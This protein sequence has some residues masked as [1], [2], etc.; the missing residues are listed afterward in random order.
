MTSSILALVAA[1]VGACLGSHA[2]TAALRSARGE[3][4][5][6]G[7]SRCDACGVTLNY[8]Q[9]APLVSFLR[10][11]GSCTACGARIDPSHVSGEAT[12]AAVLGLSFWAL[13]VMQAS[14]AGAIG[15]VL[16]AASVT[17]AKTRRLPDL[18]TLM[19]AL[20]SAGLSFAA[21][22]SSV[23]VGLA[24]GAATFLVLEACRRGFL[25]AKRQPGLGFGDV[26]LAA[27]LALWLG[28]ATPWMVAVASLGGLGFYALTRPRDPRIPF[29]PFLAASGWVIGFSRE[30]HWWPSPM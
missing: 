26:K 29:G 25:A 4:A 17:D 15:V 10:Q 12:G 16:L 30:A 7:R 3:Q 6:V 27:A 24:A 28:A 22:M 2:T 14:L 8:A 11:G 19:A 5:W 23:Y 21:G 1:A 20:G 9:T 18:L 13:P